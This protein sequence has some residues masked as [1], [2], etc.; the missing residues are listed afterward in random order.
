MREHIEKARTEPERY[1][2]DP[3]KITSW[4]L[5]GPWEENAVCVHCQNNSSG[6]RCESC[7]DGYFLLD[8]KCT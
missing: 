6:E 2:L 4:L 3:A 1:P 5:E 8:G 7:L